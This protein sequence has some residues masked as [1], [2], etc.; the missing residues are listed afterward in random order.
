MSSS[1]PTLYGA[2][3]YAVGSASSPTLYGSGYVPQTFSV[4]LSDA[5]AGTEADIVNMN[6]PLS[7]SMTL[8]EAQVK[9]VTRLLADSETVTDAVAKTIE[10]VLSE[11]SSI[12]DSGVVVMT[13]KD[14]QD[15]LV[16]K[17]WISIRL[18]KQ[19]T[20]TNPST[21]A[22]IFDTLYGRYKYGSVLFGGLKPLASWSRG[23]IGAQPSVWTN[24]NGHKYNS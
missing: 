19:I 22:N 1:Q 9:T 3:P 8:T 23:P 18:N 2:Y 17:E 14:L 16:L 20:W 15:F 21:N 10:K 11:S 24:A 13:I 7:E 6:I 12:T 5:V 4:S